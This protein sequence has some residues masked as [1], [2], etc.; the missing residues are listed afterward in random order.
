MQTIY[1]P[2]GKAREYAE[3]ALNLYRGCDHGCTYCYAPQI[4]KMSREEFHGMPTA[5]SDILAAIWKIAQYYVGKNVFL[6]FTTDPYQ[7]LNDVHNSPGILL[8][9]FTY[10]G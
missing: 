6:C 5:R 7:A 9:C 2:K 3:L 4:L 8:K 1:K 10:S